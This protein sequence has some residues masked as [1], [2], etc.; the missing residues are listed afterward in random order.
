MALHMKIDPDAPGDA[1]LVLAA[2]VIQAGGIIV[3]PTDTLYGIGANA[4][5][6]QAV[7]R[8][9]EIKRRQEAKPILI[10]VDSIEAARDVTGGISDTARRYMDRFWPGPLTLVMAAAGRLPQELSLG[11]GT[12]GVRFPRHATCRRLLALC[13]CPLTSTSANISGE[14]TPA[15]AAAIEKAIGQGIDLYLEAGILPKSPPSTV[16]DVSGTRPRLLREGAITTDQLLSVGI[17]IDR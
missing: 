13:G 17:P 8:V 15:T 6:A 1:S 11:R 7:A 5:N 4:W 14:Q 9:Q 12:V 16:L 3:Y 2:E 10:I